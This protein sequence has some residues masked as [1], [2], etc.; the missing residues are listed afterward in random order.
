MLPS[1]SDTLN[2]E[3]KS[4]TRTALRVTHTC[5]LVGMGE[6]TLKTVP[7]F[8]YDMTSVYVAKWNEMN[9][10]TRSFVGDTDTPQLFACGL[11]S[12]YDI[13]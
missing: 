12:P 9:I 3:N 6:I 13:R 7:V 1:R 11:R 8:T 5:R 2:P 4:H 10:F